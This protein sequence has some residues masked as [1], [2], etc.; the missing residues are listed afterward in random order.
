MLFAN[1]TSPLI[2]L[3]T[4]QNTINFFKEKVVKGEFDS[5]NTVTEL[6]EFIFLENK[7]I[8]FSLNSTPNSQNLPNTVI[9]NFAIN[10]L[11]TEN[12]FKHKSL[13][14]KKPYLY[15]LDEVEGIDINSETDFEIAE[16]FYKKQ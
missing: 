11:S 14:G 10:I 1:C 12:M 3:E 4:Y 15:K 9:L 13:V 5:L 2:K 8:N 7:P 6:K 16:F